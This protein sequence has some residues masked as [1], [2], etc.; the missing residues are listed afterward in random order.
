MTT[1]NSLQGNNKTFLSLTKDTKVNKPDKDDNKDLGI[2]DK[3]GVDEVVLSKSAGKTAFD[4]YVE[5]MEGGR[6]G[7]VAAFFDAID[8]VAEVIADK[9]A[10]DKKDGK[11]DGDDEK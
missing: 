5:K 4:K 10:P 1:V 7:V 11:P 3:G 8:K 2:K 6:D 9:I